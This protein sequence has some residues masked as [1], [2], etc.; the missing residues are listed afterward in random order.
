MQTMQGVQKGIQFGEI[1]D[2]TTLSR[3]PQGRLCSSSQSR[4]TETEAPP[5]PRG[6]MTLKTQRWPPMGTVQT[7]ENQVKFL[8]VLKKLWSVIFLDTQHNTVILVILKD[9]QLVLDI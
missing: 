3:G 6:Q 8:H 1:Q 4:L 9:P 2:N 7:E 5:T